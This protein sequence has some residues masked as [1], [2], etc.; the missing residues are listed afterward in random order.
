[1]CGRYYVDR[2]TERAVEKMTRKKDAGGK[3]GQGRDVSP[4]Q[5]AV[6]LIGRKGIIESGEMLWGFPRSQG[7]GLL[8]N[9]RAE[10]VLERPTSR[11]S[12]LHRRCVIPAS[13]FYEWNAAKEKVTFLRRSMNR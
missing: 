2:E 12:A 9:A 11:E 5:T 8:I 4:S 7:S 3:T 6:V 1:M 10:S 13:H